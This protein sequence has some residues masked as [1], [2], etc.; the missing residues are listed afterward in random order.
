M[1]GGARIL[2]KV[3]TD[4]TLVPIATYRRPLFVSRT[5]GG[6]SFGENTTEED[7]KK[8]GILFFRQKKVGILFFRPKDPSL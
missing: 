2:G 7:S 5:P 8:V 1:G 6:L 4:K 3:N